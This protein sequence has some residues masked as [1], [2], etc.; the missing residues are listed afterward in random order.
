LTIKL[1]VGLGNPGQDY[2]KT[3]HNAGFW[4]LDVLATQTD[5]TLSAE[6]K[7]HADVAKIDIAG[8]RVLIA[9]PKTYMNKSGQAVIALLNFYKLVPEQMLV[10]HDELDLAPGTARLKFNGG[11]GGQNGLRDIM[12]QLGHGKFHR[13][14]VGIGHPG[15]KDKVLSWVLGKP[16]VEHESA[17]SERI[18]AAINLVPNL[19]AGE[20]NAAMKSLHTPAV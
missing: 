8:Q 12:A 2:A 10:A 13:L 5:A 11:H 16:S 9:K 3:R 14:R 17:I 19:I 18:D 1:L 6:T 4:F 20:F 7:L 15:H